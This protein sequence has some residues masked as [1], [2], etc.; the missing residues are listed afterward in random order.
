MR[1]IM[2][3]KSVSVRIKNYIQLLEF[4]H[5]IHNIDELMLNSLRGWLK[6]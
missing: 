2:A 3:I 1:K 4:D 5:K 6:D